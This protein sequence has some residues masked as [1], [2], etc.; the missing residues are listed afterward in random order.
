MRRIA[1]LLVGLLAFGGVAPSHGAPNPRNHIDFWRQNY[2]VLAPESNPRVARAYQIFQRVLRAAGSRRGVVPRLVVI[3]D[4]SLTVMAIPDGGVILSTG[5][6]ERCYRGSAYGDDRLAFVLGHEIAHQL[7]DDF[8][9]MKFFQAVD[10]ARARGASTR[11]P[12]EAAGKI[13]RGTDQVLAKELEADEHGIVYAAMAGYDPR[14]IV[15]EDDKVNFFAEWV[16]ALD[17]ARLPGAPADATHPSPAV[18]AAAVKA[19]L[20]Q[21]L[22]RLDVFNL[23]ILFYQAGQYQRAI[24]AFRE[25]L[26]YFPSREVYQDLAVSHHQLA[27]EYYRRWKG[28]PAL[29]FR[30]SLIADPKSRAVNLVTRGGAGEDPERLFHDHLDKAIDLYRTAISQ[31]SSYLPAYDNLASALVV[32]GDAYE[33]VGLLQRALKQHGGA[34]SPEVLTNLGVAFYYADNLPRAEQSFRQALK[35]RPD[36][37]PALFNLARLAMLQKRV[38]NAKR[39][40]EQYLKQDP[41]GP[42]AAVAREA[43]GLSG[44][45]AKTKTPHRPAVEE[46]L[47][48]AAPGGYD[49]EVPKGWGPPR[50]RDIMLDESPY[51]LSRYRNGITTVSRNE[52]IVLLKAGHQY[53]GKTGEGITIGSP[54]RSVLEAYGEPT[55]ILD[56]TEGEVWRY[57]KPGLALRLR[58]GKVVSWLLFGQ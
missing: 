45:G 9:H 35:I 43:L 29:P 21:V 38:A 26:T 13:A 53:A 37:P 8:W 39:G 55:Q 6:L 28:K 20:R 5:A 10:E 49:D 57:R 31:D 27:L 52:E 16:A 11:A 17:P 58:D 12:L 54:T 32:N 2:D 42:W 22:E 3:K 48:G 34:S 4:K 7:K 51:R 25:F 41:G 44:A 14:A 30:V 47:A 40:W 24:A 1:V 56:L 33:A 46:S 19:R 18:R 36:Y 15:T 50:T 23:G